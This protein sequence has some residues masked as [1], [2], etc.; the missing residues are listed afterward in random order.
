M[1]HTRY[2]ELMTSFNEYNDIVNTLYRLNTFDESKINEIFEK[3]KVINKSILSVEE[4]ISIISTASLYR[5]RYMK[6]YFSIF[7]KVYDEYHPTQIRPEKIIYGLLSFFWNNDRK[8]IFEKYEEQNYSIKNHEKGT[9]YRAIMEDDMN[10]FIQFTEREDFDE[11]QLLKSDFY[12]YFYKGYSL[13]ELCCYHGSVNCF[14]LLISKFQSKITQKCL[15]FSFLSGNA[16][17]MSE[18]LKVQT[19]NKSTMEYA[20]ISHN[21]DFISF[22]MNEYNIDI[23]LDQCC[24]Y[25]NIQ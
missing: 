1:N 19:P 25:H 21:I 14:K 6:S 13:I 17:I 20:I 11:D 2:D 15:E 18:C 5:N 16:E 8:Q 9:I 24:K 10:S 3:I 7:K 23:D 22:L 12:P 4:I